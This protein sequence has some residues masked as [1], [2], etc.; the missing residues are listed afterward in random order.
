MACVEC[1]GRDD[2]Y[3][4]RAALTGNIF[5]N[6]LLHWTGQLPHEGVVSSIAKRA[7]L[8]VS[9]SATFSHKMYAKF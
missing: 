3:G 8:L 4:L 5:M 9:C 1:A 6:C 7:L 2:S